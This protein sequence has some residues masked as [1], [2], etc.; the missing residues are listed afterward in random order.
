VWRAVGPMLAERPVL[1][2]GVGG[3]RGAYPGFALPEA[4]DERGR[5][6]V[7]ESPHNLEASA[8]VAGGVPAL[9]ALLATLGLL[10]GAVWRLTR[11]DPTNNGGPSPDVSRL[12]AVGAGLAG[13]ITALQ[14]HFLT[15]DT[16]ALA[17]VLAGA[18][19][20]GSC[21]PRA[22]GSPARA[23]T[24]GFVWFAAAGLALACAALA[25]GAVGA[26]RALSDAFAAAERGDVRATTT[27]IEH[28]RS[29][30]PWEPAVLWA[31]GRAAT[32][33]VGAGHVSAAGQGREAFDEAAARMGGDSTVLRGRADL[34][35]ASS[36][37]SGDRDALEEALAAYTAVEERAPTDPLAALGS[38]AALASLGRL[39][40]A[41]HAFERA[42][43]LAPANA[44]AW[45]NLARVLQALGREQE[46]AQ[47]SERAAGLR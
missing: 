24:A 35:L 13:G 32:D 25:A 20:G 17:A 31:R 27:A 1:G 14:A 43:Q 42:T 4:T 26:D 16:A 11:R 21:I 44:A 12:A 36:L 47:A 10:G 8:A 5:G 9:I 34:L 3:F 22:G 46:A 28:A 30:A 41:A 19:I 33:L 39:D 37:A 38:G 40:E 15:L 7:L 29:L 2:W 18:L 6:Q 45:A 23:R